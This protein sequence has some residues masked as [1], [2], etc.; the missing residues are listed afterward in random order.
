MLV[1]IHGSKH[2][3][4]CIPFCF[5]TPLLFPFAL[6]ITDKQVLCC[7]FVTVLSL[8]LRG[9]LREFYSWSGRRKPRQ[10]ETPAIVHATAITSPSFRQWLATLR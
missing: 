3:G 1:L 8:Y 2:A 4:V 10:Y 5:G 9:L 7:L 6:S